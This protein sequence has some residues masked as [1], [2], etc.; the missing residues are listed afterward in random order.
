ME[1]CRVLVVD[2]NRDAAETTALFLELAGHEVKT[3]NDGM[4]ALDCA[5]DFGP[6]VVVLDIGL[7][8]MNGYEVARRLRASQPTQSALLIALT[9]YGQ[10]N[11]RQQAKEAGFDA[12]LVKPAE[13]HVLTR[14]IAEWSMADPGEPPSLYGAL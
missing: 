14:L 1:R 4:H 13:P 5:L 11:D 3:V 7:P 12:H 9:G 2:D 8:L 10:Q 6:D